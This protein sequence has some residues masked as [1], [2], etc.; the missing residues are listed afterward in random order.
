MFLQRGQDVRR[1]LLDV[2]ILR[3][4]RLGATQRDVVT[5]LL[6]RGG[7]V[8]SVELGPSKDLEMIFERSI[9]RVEHDRK[10]NVLLR[11]K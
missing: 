7:D 11:R 1:V 9:L 10:R 3:D 5:M 4:P 2:L 8:R 6:E